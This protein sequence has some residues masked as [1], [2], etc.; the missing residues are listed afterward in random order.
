MS[1]ASFNS[2]EWPQRTGGKKLDSAEY[3]YFSGTYSTRQRFPRL[4]RPIPAMRPEYDVVVIGS[5][6]GG[7]VAASRMARAGKTV[8]VLEIGKERWRKHNTTAL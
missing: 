5:G 7:G 3:S 4:G 2:Q 6:Y 1:T 8:A